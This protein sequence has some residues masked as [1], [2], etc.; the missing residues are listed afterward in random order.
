MTLFRA[1]LLCAV[2]ALAGCSS[3]TISLSPSILGPDVP[4][5]VAALVALPITPL[6][7]VAMLDVPTYE[8]SGQ[9]VHP[10]VVRFPQPWHGWEYWMAFT[11]YPHAQVDKEN[12]SIAVSHDGIRWQVPAGLTNPIIRTPAKGY[13]SDPDLSYDPAADRLV[14]MYREVSGGFNIIKTVSS[15]DGI[16][17]SL[18]R[19]TFRRREHGI[20]SPTVAVGPGGA[21][22]VWYID[23]G[24]RR[25]RER[26]TR[27]FAQTTSA[28]GALQPARSEVDWTP[29]R[30]I[31]LDQ[32]G[33]SVW[34]LDVTWVPERHEYWAIFPANR[35][36]TCYG[37]ELFFARSSDGVTWTTY[38]TPVMRRGDAAWTGAS[39]YRGSLLYDATRQS[40]RIYF[41]ASARGDIWHLGMIEYR[42]DEF[43]AALERTPRTMPTSSAPVGGGAEVWEP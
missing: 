15:G 10:D 37:R 13:N 24:N 4:R 23:A 19:V 21:P 30:R 20:V 14:L 34:H 2:V 17:W 1:T 41:S 39:L 26:V 11:P 5:D 12:P 25:C 18:P 43:I 29:P 6:S 8:G 38:R 42:V 3:D 7:P 27:T 32:P 36:F 22:T 33:Y 28:M 16:R 40:I 9:A 35:N 31:R